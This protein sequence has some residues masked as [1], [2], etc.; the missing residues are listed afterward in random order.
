MPDIRAT[1]APVPENRIEAFSVGL[2]WLKKSHGLRLDASHYNPQLAMCLG[3]LRRSGLPLVPLGELIEDVFIPPRCRRMY[4]EDP[5][6]GLPF[7]QGVHVVHFIPPDL[8][9]VSRQAQKH[10]ERW[11]IRAGWVLITRSGTVGRTVIAPREWNGWAAS[12][13]ILRVIPKKDASI[14]VGY[15]WA[16]LLS[17]Y[18]Q[19]QLTSRIYGAVVDE[20]TEDQVRNV[21]VPVPK[22]AEQATMVEIT[23]CLAAKALSLRGEA[24][25][26]A[27][28]AVSS[29]E[30]LIHRGP[31][32]KEQRRQRVETFAVESACLVQSDTTRLDASHYNPD[33]ARAKQA[34][35]STGM[36]LK[37]L[38]QVT[39][40]VFIPPRFK[41]IYVDKDHGI[42]FL[43]GSHVVHFQPADLKY[44]S[45]EAQKN[46]D[47]WIIEHGWVLVTCS[48]T[49]G[50]VTIAPDGWHLWAAS[51]HILRIV[52]NDEGPCPGGYV[53]AFLASSCGQ[54][55]LTSHIYG[56]VVDELT[57]DQ[58]RSIMIPIPRTNR[59][60]H[61]VR[62]I[63]T[64][65]L[66]ATKKK[67]QAVD[68]VERS[69]T[70]VQQLIE[71]ERSTSLV[72]KKMQ[73]EQ[74]G[75]ASASLSSQ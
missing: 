44:L 75:F 20:L 17:Q 3:I 26:L 72:A 24:K 37:R 15:L 5:N 66:E 23:S 13:H 21:L 57:E 29:V 71:R 32:V 10:L 50:R 58:A 64:L 69:L 62:A 2:E 54:A 63:N 8:K 18:G 52:P 46:L 68:L 16:F 12:E 30:A 73:G 4:V 19:V 34:L 40:R 41:R 42:P 7:L 45:R 35:K 74:S 28:N 61:T 31:K 33:L 70:Q 9:Y 65:A 51:Q 6:H 39:G 53:Y 11:I 56:A 55:Q 27:E 48:G 25:R 60:R 67:Q 47:T 14:P 1:A 22:T 36:P 38:E 59:Q 43:Q 49:I